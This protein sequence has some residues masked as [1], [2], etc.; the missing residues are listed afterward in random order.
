MICLDVQPN[1]LEAGVAR[2]PLQLKIDNPPAQTETAWL[3]NT[4]TQETIA[5]VTQQP[6]APHLVRFFQGSGGV[7]AV[8]QD[9]NIIYFALPGSHLSVNGTT[10]HFP[11]APIT[12]KYNAVKALKP[13]QPQ[14]VTTQAMILGAG[15]GKRFEPISGDTTG[16]AKPAVPLLG[17]DAVITTIAKHLQRHGIQKIFINT[18]YKPDC[19]KAQ[20]QNLPGLEIVFIDEPT[21]SGTAGGL[22]KVFEAGLANQNEPILIIQ[23]DAVTDADFSLLL[24]THVKQNAA[25]TIGG[26]IVA[27]ED[28]NK[29]G[30]IE[31]DHSDPDGQSG[32][33]TS[34]KEKPSLAEAGKSRFGNAGFYV[35]SP[36]VYGLFME[37]ADAIMSSC[38]LFD[39][40]KHFFSIVLTRIQTDAILH[41]ET[42][43]PL[44][45][46][47]QTMPG[48]WSD[49]GNPTQ[50]LQTLRDIY[51]GHLNFPLPTP[52]ANTYQDGI[53]YWPG[54][55]AIATSQQ[56]QLSG[57][58]I[59]AKPFGL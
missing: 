32:N 23:G 41:P 9:K 45:F 16:Y 49:I 21:P 38:G 28:V 7:C 40:A 51:S 54:T 55:K 57:N 14:T 29:F 47:A 31:T 37:A 53:F 59:V 30:I 56:A 22:A 19:L 44:S 13:I 43:T 52:I 35:L 50:Y 12:G 36:A 46:W 48:Y 26:Q 11:G 10:L 18:S 24:N 27:D 2:L 15:Y 6:S 4:Q 42:K 17:D 8:I 34:F 39:Y 25:I 1:L 33:I 5:T 58:I 20:L 3:L